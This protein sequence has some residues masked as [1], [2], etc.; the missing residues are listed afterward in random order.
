MGFPLHP[1][2][3]ATPSG[4][5][6]APP[7]GPGL[8]TVQALKGVPRCTQAVAKASEVVWSQRAHVPSSCTRVLLGGRPRLCRVHPR[9]NTGPRGGIGEGW[10]SGCGGC[11]IEVTMLHQRWGPPLWQ[12]FPR[13]F[14][15]HSSTALLPG[16][17][18]H[19]CWERSHCAL[20]RTLAVVLVAPPQL[21][22]SCLHESS[23]GPGCLRLSASLPKAFGV[24][25]GP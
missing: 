20:P 7:R 15:P 17:G 23:P 22:P 8:I 11:R 4:V 14:C 2:A 16:A 9:S 21:P 25:P 18:G 5:G 12:T 24:P 6:S 3:I 19:L 1:V 10:G 13:P